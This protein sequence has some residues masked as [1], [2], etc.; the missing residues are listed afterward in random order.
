MGAPNIIP[1]FQRLIDRHNVHA[2]INGY[3][4]GA[5]TAEY[6]TIADAG[7]IYIHHNTD[8]VHHETVG[9]DPETYFGVFMAIRPNIGTGQ[10]CFSFRTTSKRPGNTSI[11]TRRLR[12]S[13]VSK[14][15][16]DDRS[17]DS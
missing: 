7:I 17:S 9:N 4:T 15:Q 14:L 10:G 11:R 5:V 2:I 6:D 1:A 8:I 3:N 12:L 13:P 16:R